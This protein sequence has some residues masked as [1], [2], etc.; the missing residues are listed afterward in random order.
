MSTVIKAVGVTFKNEN[1]VKL[2][3]F[4]EDGLIGAYRF[5]G[6]SNTKDLSGSGNDLTIDGAPTQGSNYVEGNNNN[7]YDTGIVAQPSMTLIATF[8]VI[9]NKS[10]FAVGTYDSTILKGAGLYYSTAFLGLSKTVYVESG[11]VSSALKPNPT[12]HPMGSFFFG[13]MSI[14]AVGK[15]IIHGIPSLGLET[16]SLTSSQS[17][18]SPILTSTHTIKILSS[19]MKTAT[20]EGKLQIAEVLIYNRALSESEIMAQYANSKADLS[21]KGILI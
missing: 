20:W 15:N 16:H 6:E 19:Y 17:L 1:L 12:S 13:A 4:I 8:K 2:N 7:G 11:G 10:A 9:E 3:N 14:D 5:F 21:R 18:I